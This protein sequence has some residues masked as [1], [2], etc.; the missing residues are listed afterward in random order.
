VINPAKKP[1]GSQRLL[2]ASDKVVLKN[3]FA[4]RLT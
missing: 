3:H 4:G 2:E 1:E